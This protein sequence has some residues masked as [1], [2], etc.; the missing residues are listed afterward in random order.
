MFVLPAY[1]RTRKV[2]TLKLL[3]VVVVGRLKNRHAHNNVEWRGEKSRTFKNV[4][5]DLK[6]FDRVATFLKQNWKS[7]LALPEGHI[8]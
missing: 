3:L 4:D 1:N 8:D 5:W 6:G 7:F 2:Y